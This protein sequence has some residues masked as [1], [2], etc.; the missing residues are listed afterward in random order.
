MADNELSDFQKELDSAVQKA[1]QDVCANHEKMSGAFIGVV[2]W[3]DGNDGGTNVFYPEEQATY[4]SLG[5]SNYLNLILKNLFR[6][7]IKSGETS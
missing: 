3:F 5:L 7:K 4:E 6:N 1:V 2:R